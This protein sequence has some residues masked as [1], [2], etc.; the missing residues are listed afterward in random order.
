[1]VLVSAHKLRYSYDHRPLIEDLS[2]KLDE[3]SFLWVQGPNGCGKTTLLTIVAGFVDA[4]EGTLHRCDSFHCIFSKPVLPAHTSIRSYLKLC[5][6][7]SKNQGLEPA[8]EAA[9]I[10]GLKDDLGHQFGH[11]SDG[12]KQRL[13]WV[14]LLLQKRPLW[15][16]DEPLNH[17]DNTSIKIFETILESHKEQGGSA[18]FSSH[19]HFLADTH[20][21]DLGRHRS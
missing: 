18:L 16:M 19:R 9:E 1:M 11:L 14:P 6:Q 20:V 3:G 8:I 13:M 17:L 12:Q 21:L 15:I 2:F 5:S 4:H 10:L 7:L